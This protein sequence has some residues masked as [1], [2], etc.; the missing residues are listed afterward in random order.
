MRLYP[1]H[2]EPDQFRRGPDVELLFDVH[3]MDFDGLGADVEPG[4]N[5][6]RSQA[7]ANE[8]EDFELTIGQLLDRR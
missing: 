3:A 7:A 5:L 6:F 4:R 8:L 1:A 2:C